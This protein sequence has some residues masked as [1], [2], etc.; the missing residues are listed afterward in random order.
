[1]QRTSIIDLAGDPPRIV[2]DYPGYGEGVHWSTDGTKLAF[3]QGEEGKYCDS[4]YVLDLQSGAKK[5]VRPWSLFGPR[6]C[7]HGPSWSP[8]SKMLA[9]LGYV[10]R[11]DMN[12]L[13]WP[14]DISDQLYIADQNMTVKRVTEDLNKPNVY[15]ISWC[16][17]PLA[18]EK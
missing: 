17:K 13:P 11:G 4:I 2:R 3:T 6:V 18:F 8:D 14:N 7:F 1:M 15:G 5:R 10:S 9:F 16:T 12:P